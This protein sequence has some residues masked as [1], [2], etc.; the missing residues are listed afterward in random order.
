MIRKGFPVRVT[1]KQGRG[2]DEFFRELEIPPEEWSDPGLDLANTPRRISKMLKEELL[3]SYKPGALEALKAK[4]TR[5]A[6]DGQDAMVFEG[7]ISFHSTCAHHLLPFSG[8]AYVAYIPDRCL[9]GASK[10]PRVVEHFARMLQLQERLARQT[11]DFIWNEASP[12]LVIVLLSAAHLCMRCRGVKQQN[13]KMVTTAIR[14]QP[15]FPDDNEL[16]PVLDE[17][18]AQLAF[19]SK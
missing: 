13:T 2:I 18:Y 12:R 10:I 8:E 5:F 11:A 15:S 17:F 16:R 4:F 6:S 3:S 7:P 14:P 9:I 1:P 19:V